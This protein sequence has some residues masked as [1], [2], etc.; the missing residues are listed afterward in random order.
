MKKSSNIT[1]WT[2]GALAVFLVFS[3]VFSPSAVGISVEGNLKTH[4][5][6]QKT[7]AG[8]FDELGVSIA[9]GAQVSCEGVQ[10]RAGSLRNAL[11]AGSVYS[12]EKPK[13][14][15]IQDG[16]RTVEVLSTTATLRDTALSV[17]IVLGPLDRIETTANPENPDQKIHK[18][19]RVEHKI[20][21]RYRDIPYELRYEPN[22]RVHQGKI[23]KWQ[24]GTG[25]EIEETFRE[26]YENGELMYKTLIDTRMTK[27]PIHEVIAEGTADMPGA[28][29]TVFEVESTAY[30]P[31]VEECDSDPTTCATGMKSGYG[32]VAVY[33]KQ[34]P[35]YTEMYIEGY[36]YAIA[37]DCGGAIGQNRIDVFFYD[38]ESARKWGRRKVKVYVLKWPEGF[39]E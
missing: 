24:P 13:P 12:V 16:N 7:V 8:L 25:G 17:G 21:K 37:G 32:V 28:Y 9:D 20:T 30:T 34:I 23:V 19:V 1:K 33:P 3:A 4:I 10:L 11:A 29:K 27:R 15:Q 36:G 5:T 38:K 26:V 35:Y 2:I 18:V 6:Y 39:E 22:D 14:V 31:S